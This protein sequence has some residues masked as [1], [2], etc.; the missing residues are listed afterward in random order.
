MPRVVELRDANRYAGADWIGVRQ[1]GA[2]TLVGVDTT[3]LG[4]G[5]WAML[6]LFGAVTAAWAWEGRRRSP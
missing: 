5:L 3:P 6:I 1:T 4:I 2:S